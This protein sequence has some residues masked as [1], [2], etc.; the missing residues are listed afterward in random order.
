MLKYY[1]HFWL[2]LCLESTSGQAPLQVGLEK[3]PPTLQLSYLSPFGHS[4][5][6]SLLFSLTL[7]NN[8]ITSHEIDET[9]KQYV[10]LI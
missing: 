6:D 8:I 2:I 10:V 9:G 1:I 4:S 7:C 3:N 5:I